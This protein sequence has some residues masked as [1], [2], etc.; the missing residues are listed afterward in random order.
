MYTSV[1]HFQWYAEM[2]ELPTWDPLE[3]VKNLS[4]HLFRICYVEVQELKKVNVVVRQKS[5]EHAIQ[6][7]CSLIRLQF[8]GFAISRKDLLKG[9]DQFLTLFCLQR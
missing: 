7:L 4:F 3:T 1:I 5:V 6:K 9:F 8:R 2:N